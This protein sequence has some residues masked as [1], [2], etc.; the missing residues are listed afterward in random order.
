MF[1]DLCRKAKWPSAEFVFSRHED[2]GKLQ[3]LG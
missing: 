1:K 3:L 2:I